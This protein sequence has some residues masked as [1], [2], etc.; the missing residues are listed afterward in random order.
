[1]A[2]DRVVSPAG[3]LLVALATVGCARA[4]IT[5]LPLW[6]VE[7]DET[8]REV[9]MVTLPFEQ[10]SYDMKTHAVL[11][12]VQDRNQDGISDRIT[13]YEGF[14]GARTVETDTDFDG[15]VDRWE[16]FGPEGQRMRSATASNGVR[17][18]RVATYDRAGLLSRVEVDADLDGRFEITRIYEAGKLVEVRIDSDG[19]GRTDRIQDFRKGYLSA[20]DFDTDED[21]TPDLRMTFGKD[22]ALLKVSVLGSGR[23]TGPRPDDRRPSAA[24]EGFGRRC[25]PDPSPRPVCLWGREL[26]DLGARSRG[27]GS[28]SEAG[29][30]PGGAASPREGSQPLSP[31][32]PALLAVHVLLAIQLIPL[33]PAFLRVLSPG[34]YAARYIPPMAVQTWAPLTASPTGT[35]QAWLFFAGL[36]GLAITLFGAKAST[37]TSRL[38]PL[39]TGMAAIGALLAL[40]GLVQAASAHPYWLYGVFPVPG[41][42]EHERG[43]FGPYYNRDHYSNLIAIAASVAAGLLA[44]RIPRAVPSSA[45]SMVN[46]PDFPGSLALVASL[47]LMFAASAASGSRGG[48]AAIGAGVL[49]GLSSPFLSRPR[50]ALGSAVL[51]IIVLFGT[52][53][54]S[55]IARMSDVDF[56]TSRLMVWRDTLRLLEFFPV[57]GCGIGAFAPAYWPYQRV[58]RFEYWPHAHNEYLQWV[59]EAGL[60]GIL[61]A[62]YGMRAAWRAA[63]Q[64]IRNQEVRPAL[65]G[66]TAAMVH[67]LVE[68]SLRIPANAAWAGVL[69][70]CL[71]ASTGKERE[72]AAPKA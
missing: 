58:V 27:C 55:A 50:L 29:P 61:M 6:R 37:R 71:I 57:F 16:T 3:L 19:D 15:R 7:I 14:G 28:F 54:P 67:A 18:D 30:S 45:L 60:V 10:I 49:V 59:L 62:L 68:C 1:M 33:P 65:A 32:T 44:K 51:L 39:F 43:L 66:L 13:T 40:E 70:A 17:P 8:G 46:S 42:A 4:S 12:D 23:K 48:L 11:K 56:E 52:G 5:D 21:G 34:S 2:P 22:G 20:E 35:G 26:H 63:P 25:P 41:I 31:I 53:V 64:M 38:T 9:R 72:H 24:D 36:H 69:L 47:V